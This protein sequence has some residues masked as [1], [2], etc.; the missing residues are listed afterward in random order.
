MVPRG[1][2]FTFY[3]SF[4][5]FR[6][7]HNCN[8]S[9]TGVDP[10][11]FKMD[12]I[13]TSEQDNQIISNHCKQDEDFVEIDEYPDSAVN[14][15]PKSK[16]TKKSMLPPKKKQKQPTPQSSL[17]VYPESKPFTLTQCF[18]DLFKKSKP[19]PPKLVNSPPPII[20]TTTIAIPSPEIT[21]NDVMLIEDEDGLIP[22]HHQQYE[23]IDSFVLCDIFDVLDPSEMSSKP[24][25][26]IPT[27]PES[28]F[29]WLPEY[30]KMDPDSLL[31]PEYEMDFIV[32]KMESFRSIMFYLDE[33]ECG[34]INIDGVGRKMINNNDSPSYSPLPTQI[35]DLQDGGLVEKE[36]V[37]QFFNDDDQWLL[38]VGED[39]TKEVDPVKNEET[40][41]TEPKKKFVFKIKN[42]TPLPTPPPPESIEQTIT[43]ENHN[44]QSPLRSRST[45]IQH[46]SPA[47]AP[48]IT[49]S[50]GEASSS[51]TS[52][53]EEFKSP[54]WRKRLSLQYKHPTSP[55]PSSNGE[56][57]PVR[58]N[59]DDTWKE[60][61][62]AKHSQS[63]QFKSQ[64]D[65]ELFKDDMLLFDD[66]VQD[67]FEPDFEERP[68]TPTIYENIAS[69]QKCQLEPT[70]RQENK[71]TFYN[72][73]FIAP[74]SPPSIFSKNR[75]FTKLVSKPVPKSD[76]IS[77]TDSD[78]EILELLNLT[79]IEQSA[80][81]K[82]QEKLPINDSYKLTMNNPPKFTFKKSTSESTL[83]PCSST[84][85]PPKINDWIDLTH[86][87]RPKN[88]N[89]L[90]QPESKK[91]SQTIKNPLLRPS[92]LPSIAARIPL[93]V[94][95]S[96]LQF[97][98]EKADWS[99]DDDFRIPG[100]RSKATKQTNRNLIKSPSPT[101]LS[102]MTT[103]SDTFASSSPLRAIPSSSSRNLNPTFCDISPIA[104]TKQ[105][106][107]RRKIEI[108]SF[109]QLEAEVSEN[110]DDDDDDD[111][112][113]DRYDTSFVDSDD[114]DVLTDS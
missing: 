96:K 89:K 27:P 57:N 10:Q 2:I 28:E 76:L 110:D 36:E 23:P 16:Q 4:C 34:N 85:N 19:S 66:D 103:N 109:L 60:E 94:R 90:P 59:N 63:Q 46:S 24:C 44:L 48:I 71:S 112:G 11:C 92:P 64:I 54:N 22:H 77:N 81:R 72:T 80:Y 3:Y 47:A 56:C 15:K 45:G 18:N 62:P 111:D 38:N 40:F 17:N 20:T 53:D 39:Y 6:I 78:D 99:D 95:P 91:R 82:S 31:I 74:P 32:Q 7:C 100:N 83:K 14:I 113:L 61:L 75:H 25:L 106:K 114:E 35:D 41:S 37:D 42:N 93:K 67:D 73:N 104:S 21:N 58:T 26:H 8:L 108:N 30:N 79:Q 105:R 97:Q 84:S 50:D 87:N 12:I 55:P 70:V 33:C 86:T 101:L 52:N 5:T 13:L 9:T 1:K 49:I 65:P 102:N 43:I 98:D 68:L 107:K 88:T 51:T 69:Q 29:E